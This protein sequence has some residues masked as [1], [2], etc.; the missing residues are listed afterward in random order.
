[1][2]I[3]SEQ[4]KSARERRQMTQQE[5]ADEVG[6][7]LRRVGSWERG[8][9]IPRNRMG[10]IA[11]A[12]GL[13]DEVKGRD[14]GP[15]AIRRRLG[16]LAKQRREQLGLARIPFAKHAGMYEQAVMQFEFAQRWPR[17]ATLRKLEDALG[18]KPFVTEDILS[19][20]RRASTIELADLD[21]PGVV[22]PEPG[23][24]PLAGVSTAD[25]LAELVR[26]NNAQEKVVA[27]HADPAQHHYDLAAS[28]DHV[29]GEDD[30]D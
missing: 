26:R 9:S 15:E 20:S 7:S 5:L 4:I 22:Q 28:D 12:L 19:S 8:E 23:S 27:E 17:T 10:A 3:T 29:E 6:V 30:N 21:N 13:D 1:M 2:Y 24:I 18:W 25:L 14:F 11:E 16:Q